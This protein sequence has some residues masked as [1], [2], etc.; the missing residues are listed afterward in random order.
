VVVVT[1]VLE[2]LTEAIV[3]SQALVL[4][5]SLPQVEAA[6]AQNLQIVVNQMMVVLEAAV[7]V[8]MAEIRGKKDKA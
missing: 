2:A 3:Q 1:L 8:L 4:Q 7:L 5:Q 6:V